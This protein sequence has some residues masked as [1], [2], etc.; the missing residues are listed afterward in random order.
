MT[1]E[2]KTISAE[3]ARSNIDEYFKKKKE[4]EKQKR[5]KQIQ[6]VFNLIEEDSKQGQF[7]VDIKLSIM[8]EEDW[9]YTFELLDKLGYKY[10]IGDGGGIIHPYVHISWK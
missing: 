8:K 9:N 5:I 7:Y 2:L 4:E 6:I 1:M 10:N 3:A